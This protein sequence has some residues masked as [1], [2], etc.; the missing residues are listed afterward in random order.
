MGMCVLVDAHALGM[1]VPMLVAAA[2]STPSAW[3]QT[4]REPAAGSKA[5]FAHLTGLP[6]KK[7]TNTRVAN[8]ARFKPRAMSCMK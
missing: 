6:L 2:I 1:T 8:L 7:S 3:V 5:L 4:N